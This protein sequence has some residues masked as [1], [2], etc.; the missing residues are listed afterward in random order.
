[1]VVDA[2]YDALHIEGSVLSRM[3]YVDPFVKTTY[4]LEPGQTYHLKLVMENEIATLYIDD[5]KVLCVRVYKAMDGGDIGI[6]AVNTEA[7][8]PQAMI[9]REIDGLVQ[10]FEY[11][12]MYQGLKLNDYLEFL[13]ISS[14]V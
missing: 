6:F 3:A 5:A 2:K 14:V 8:I 13:K 9:D 1:M 4:K 12:L 7:E 10:K 11:Q